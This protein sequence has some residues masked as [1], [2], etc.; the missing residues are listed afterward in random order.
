M[1]SYDMPMDSYG[2]GGSGYGA[3]Q[4][5]GGSAAAGYSQESSAGAAGY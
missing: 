4:S 5:Y 1:E 2:A 3:G